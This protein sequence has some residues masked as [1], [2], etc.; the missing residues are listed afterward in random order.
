M[1][2]TF[3]VPTLFAKLD[4]RR[5]VQTSSKIL[6]TFCREDA[7]YAFRVHENRN[8]NASLHFFT[9]YLLSLLTQANGSAVDSVARDMMT[10]VQDEYGGTE[11]YEERETIARNVTG[12]AYGGENPYSVGINI[13]LK[14][15]S[16]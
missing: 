3:P 5:E 9:S 15:S 12:V 16:P 11:L 13:I 8:R 2:R 7:G 4:S 14:A 6:S 10:K 1:G